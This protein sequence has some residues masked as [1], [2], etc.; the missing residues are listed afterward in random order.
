MLHSRH[1]K[2]LNHPSPTLPEEAMESTVPLASTTSENQPFST[3]QELLDHYQTNLQ[4]GLS[5]LDVEQRRRQ[6]SQSQNIVHPPIHCPPWV[7]CLLPCIKYVPVQKA[8]L[9]LSL[10]EDAQVLRNGSWIHY[11]ATSLVVGD[12]I[13][14]QAGDI[15]PADCIYVGHVE[16]GPSQLMVDARVVTG[17]SALIRCGA[18]LS[19]NSLVQLYYGSR[20]VEEQQQQQCTHLAVVTAIGNDTALGLLIQSKRFPIEPSRATRRY[21]DDEAYD[22]EY[23]GGARYS[24]HGA[25]AATT[26]SIALTAV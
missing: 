9:A 13:Q 10:P 15:V 7:C 14:L 21:A 6:G 2:H 19:A 24:D 22:E 20:V 25:A 17:H 23:A 18:N 3:L 8:F 4:S 11:D 1:T 5:S 16:Q 12:I 26:S